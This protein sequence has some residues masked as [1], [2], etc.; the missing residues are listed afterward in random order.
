MKVNS[1][2]SWTIELKKII[3]FLLVVL[4]IQLS[5]GLLSACSSDSVVIDDDT[6]ITG[7]I[8]SRTVSQSKAE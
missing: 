4:L 2:R 5:M 3:R 7:N 6:H 8:G 1:L